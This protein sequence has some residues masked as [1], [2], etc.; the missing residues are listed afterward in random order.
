MTEFFLRDDL[1]AN[2]KIGS[3]RETQDDGVKPPLQVDSC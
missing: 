1:G 2:R 3:S